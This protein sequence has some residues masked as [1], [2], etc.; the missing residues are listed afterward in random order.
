MNDD[1]YARKIN[2]KC[3]R[4]MLE[5]D[6]IFRKFFEKTFPGLSPGEQQIFAEFLD[7]FDPV[8]ADWIFG[9]HPPADDRFDNI[10]KR[11]RNIVSG[12]D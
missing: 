2:W 9:K 12:H 3:R 7:E 11:M 6:L 10:V 8:L 1:D 4:G 5:L